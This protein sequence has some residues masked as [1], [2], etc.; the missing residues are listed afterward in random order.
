MHVLVV[1]DQALNRSLLSVMLKQQGYQV[2]TANNGI[3]ALAVIDSQSIDI[4]LLDVLMPEMDGYETAPKIKQRS[5]D[6]YLPI[7]FITSL[8]DKD[9]LE[10]CLAVGGDDFIHKPFDK[11]ILTAKIKAHS[12]TRQL[13]LKAHEQNAQLEYHY[14]QTEREHEIVEHIFNNALENQN[15][16]SN[17]IDFH[18]SPASMFNGDML[19]VAQS[20]IGSLYC[21]LGDFTGHGLAAAVGALPASKVFYTMVN[22][23]MAVNDIAHEVNT[24]LAKLLPGHMFCAATIIELSSS[25]KSISAWLGGL[26]DAYVIDQQGKVLK[27]LESQHMALGILDADEFERELIHFEVDNTTR[28]VLATDGIIETANDEDEYFGEQRFIQVLGSKTQVSCHDIIEQVTKF[29]KGSKQQD[30]LS[31]V[32]FNCLPVPSSKA[33]AETYS[34][35]PFNFSLSLNSAQIKQTDPVL[36]VVD[37]ITRVSGLKAHRSDIFLLLSEAYNN[38]V[39]HGL[40]GLDSDIKNHDDGFFEFYQQREAALA[41]LQGAMII[42]EIRYCPESLCLYFTICDS[43]N[44]FTCNNHRAQSL[45][46]EHGRGLSLLEEIAEHVGYNASGNQIEMCYKLT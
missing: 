36:E 9:S 2:T 13:S 12:R 21:M 44:G 18:L 4:V 41:S 8:E 31:L 6:V 35:L 26:P 16:F 17:N 38:A 24:V 7:I 39:D 14:N 25:G 10:H 40:L 5:E 33:E 45:A 27:T 29:A 22:K 3:E 34:P 19:L 20:P 11:V 28:I 30:D 23:G 32:L 46:R 15:E 37:V 1:D 43:G 42:I